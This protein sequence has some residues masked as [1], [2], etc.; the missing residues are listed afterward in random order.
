MKI[1]IKNIIFYI[2]V[3]F[4]ATYIILE[5]FIPN[6]TVDTLGFKTYV[7]VSSS[8][9]PDIMVNDL[10]IIRKVEEEKLDISDTITFFVYIP[11]LGREN[12]VTHYIGDIQEIN[13]EV[14]YKTQGA[15]KDPGDYDVWKNEN[16]EVIEVT[17]EDIEG[18]VAIVIPNMGHVVN[19]LR[20][21]ISL[22]L[23]GVNGFILY[24]LVKTFKSPKK[25]E[26][27][28]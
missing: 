10:I 4:I 7:V 12:A 22:V 20:D 28:K 8:M 19:I 18:R 24:L 27:K 23:I 2:F 3:F 16:N 9:E 1:S 11:E 5:V 26:D 6:K 25:E 21:P 14:I 13:G 15:L 17:Y